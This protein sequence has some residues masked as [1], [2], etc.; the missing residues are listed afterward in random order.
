MKAKKR[1]KRK[2][3]INSRLIVLVVI[4]FILVIIA[5]ASFRVLQTSEQ[6]RP[7]EEYFA[8]V[9][10]EYIGLPVY[11]GSLLKLS[12]L[13]FNFTAVEGDAHDVVIQPSG[14]VSKSDWPTFETIKKDEIEQVYIPFFSPLMIGRE[15]EGFPFSITIRSR[16]AYGKITIYLEAYGF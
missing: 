10:P 11:N 14:I 8:I 6:K 1:R 15:E 16:E 2:R 5:A 9:N 3:K 12:E 7:A 4:A 13:K